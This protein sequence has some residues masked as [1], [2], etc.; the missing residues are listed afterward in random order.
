MKTASL[1]KISIQVL[2]LGLL[3]ACGSTT[4]SGSPDLTKNSIS[5][6]AASFTQQ[7]IQ[8]FDKTVQQLKELNQDRQ[9]WATIIKAYSAQENLGATS[10]Y[11][12]YSTELHKTSVKQRCNRAGIINIRKALANHP[13]S[14]PVL[15]YALACAERFERSD[16]QAHIAQSIAIISEELLKQTARGDSRTTPILVRE[17]YEGEFLLG[18]AG[19]EVYETEMIVENERLL[20]LHHGIDQITSQYSISFADQSEFFMHSFNTSMSKAGLKKVLPKSEL[21]NVKQQTLLTGDHYSMVLWD[22][23]RQLYSGEYFKVIERI[24][25]NN[26]TTPSAYSMLAQAYMATNDSTGIPQIEDKLILYANLGIPESQAVSAMILLKMNDEHGNDFSAVRRLE[27]KEAESDINLI[28]NS[29]KKN[30]AI[31]GLENA[32]LVWTRTLL[33]DSSLG[34]YISE[35]VS[36]LS[37]ESIAGWQGAL[38]YIQDS[39]NERSAEFNRRIELFNRALNSLENESIVSLQGRF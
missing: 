27:N 10:R 22:I 3:G 37:P 14:I 16:Q 13:S 1:I 36:Q 9:K 32:S 24:K 25:E 29:F 15:S 7:D 35:L 12:N 38:A 4:P 26:Y 5:S 20:I 21:V 17:L 11:V 34:N 31:I 18:L 6:N 8:L 39:H 2:A 30:A 23:R 28:V 33:G 19:I